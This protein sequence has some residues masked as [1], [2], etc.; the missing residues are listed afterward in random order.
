MT[1]SATRSGGGS[2]CTRAVSWLRSDDQG[3]EYAEISFDERRL[4]ASS[5]AIGVRPLPY[6]ADLEL[7]TVDDFITSRLAINT[8]GLGWKRSIELRRS[9]EGLWSAE[10]A[11]EGEVD[12]EEP[13]GDRLQF[14]GA[15]D[16]DVELCPILNS[17]PTLRH[18]LLDGGTAPEMVMIW[19][20]LPSLTLHRSL[21]RYSYLGTDAVGNHV[22]RFETP[23]P[24]GEGFVKDITF[25]ADGIVLDYPTIARRIGYA[26]YFGSA[27]T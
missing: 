4:S 11:L 10:V 15:L 14:E 24:D 17:L 20:A 8:R 23:V 3:A 5:T 6:L 9:E 12:L 1:S 7:Q 2:V 21:Q 16:P 27:A 18:R 22:V 26:P 19:V 13:G 25:D